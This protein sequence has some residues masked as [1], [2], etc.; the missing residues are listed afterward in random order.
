MAHVSTRTAA[1]ISS[2]SPASDPPAVRDL[3]IAIYRD[4]WA[5][6]EGTAAQLIAEGLIPDGF[7]WPQADADV[8]W[9]ASGFKYWLRRTRPEGHKGPK[10]SWLGLDNWFVRIS[11][12]GRDYHWTT[13]RSLERKAQA[14]AAEFH[15]HTPVGAMEWSAK[16]N[17][18][19]EAERDQAFQAF[20]TLVPGLVPPKRGR[21]PK[22]EATQ[23]AQA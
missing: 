10:R 19:M 12:V 22:S 3:R 15:H 18:Y 7:E 16:W 1:P 20:K 14:L 9:V 17:R 6:Y 11:V 5:R 8:E 13:R 23:G 2:A 21:K 4:A